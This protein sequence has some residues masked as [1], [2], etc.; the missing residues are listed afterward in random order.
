MAYVEQDGVPVAEGEESPNLPSGPGEAGQQDVARESTDLPAIEQADDAVNERSRAGE[1]AE[2]GAE[3]AATTSEQGNEAG[4][5][6]HEGLAE[7]QEQDDKEGIRQSIVHARHEEPAGDEPDVSTMDAPALRELILQMRTDHNQ[8]LQAE[9]RAR[10]EVEDMCLRIEKHFKAEKA[11][12]GKA[13]E[14]MQ[15]AIEN[16]LSAKSQLDMEQQRLGQVENEID[17]ERE[18]VRQER[19]ALEAMRVDF[20]HE[21][22][23][24][25]TEVAKAQDA[26]KS[27]EDRVR[28][29][30]QV[31]RQKIISDYE[32]RLMSLA[33]ELMRANHDTQMRTTYMSREMHRYQ[34]AA[35]ASAS[36]VAAAKK[37]MHARRQDVDAM[38][39]KLDVVMERLATGTEAAS[40]LQANMSAGQDHAGQLFAD[41]QTMNATGLATLMPGNPSFQTEFGQQMLL[42][43]PKSL[44]RGAPAATTG[45]QAAAGKPRTIA[46]G[47]P[48]AGAIN[49]RVQGTRNSAPVAKTP[50]P[51]K[52]AGGRAIGKHDSARF[53][54]AKVRNENAMAATMANW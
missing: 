29:S 22:Q 41:P 51:S 31:E 47:N 4:D 30:E 54:G 34:S 50:G 9:E 49:N 40:V 35:A 52:V 5:E 2:E 39:S 13:E 42:G 26:L 10:A 33:N 24:A 27:A 3:P 7:I 19:D 23:H 48:P 8:Q 15:H 14:L 53:D 32:L 1:A 6:E 25:Q 45:R 11:A 36:A 18:K 37:E 46:A 43:A 17:M 38:R 21:L 28:A 16:E 20:E 12:R 44:A